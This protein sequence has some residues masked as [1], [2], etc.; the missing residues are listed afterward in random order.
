MIVFKDNKVKIKYIEV[1]K[2]FKKH[3]FNLIFKKIMK[4]EIIKLNKIS[5]NKEINKKVLRYKIIKI[6]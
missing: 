3:Q 6:C 1:A 4:L 5:F 2:I